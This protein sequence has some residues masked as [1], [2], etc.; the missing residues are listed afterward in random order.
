MTA[1][2]FELNDPAVIA[3][4][5]PYY[6]RLRDQ[7]PVYHCTNPD[8][9][10]LTRY[11]DVVAAL[12]DV[13]RFSSD[14]SHIGTGT[15][16]FNPSAG[17]S[18]RLT[19]LLTRVSWLRVLLTSDP[20]EHTALRRKVSRAFT[21]KMM[22]AWETRVR[23]IAEGLVDNMTARG[24]PS[25]DLV[26]DLASPLPTTVIAEMMG[27]PVQRH[28]D[29][30]R[31]SDHLVDGLL[32]G[33]STLNMAVSAVEILGF[34]ANIVRQR[35]QHPGDD[36]VSLLVT[37]HE[38][39]LNVAELVAFCVLLLVA[40][41]ETTTNLISNTMLALFDHPDLCQ[42]LQADPSLAAAAVE[43][44]LRYDGP[45][46]GLM[47]ATTTDV[48]IR[49]VTIPARNRVMPMIASA[50][51][52]PRHWDDPDTFRLDR[53]LNGHL[54]FGTGIHYCIGN[55]LARLEGRIAVETLFRRLPHMRPAAEPKRI[56]SP[57]LRG[58]RSLPVSTSP[59]F[60]PDA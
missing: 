22:G 36:L 47:R 13:G 8:V 28:D 33:G 24:T 15:N 21:P 50:N 59:T 16:P 44:T 45:G 48:E 11:D 34:F 32:T 40:G 27:I 37:G 35:R 4:P 14:R 55:A 3:D 29:F 46:Q 60:K 18:V 25:C 9:W 1:A 58:L 17:L 19:S 30:K 41:N 5:Y 38:E 7:A 2:L 31:W 56:N 12:R 49:S 52:D 54:A 26:A 6:T 39:S 51:R 53:D 57:V 20:P 43:E 10:V 42:Q 23:E